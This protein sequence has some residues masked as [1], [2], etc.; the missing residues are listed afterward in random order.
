MPRSASATTS[1]RA[2]R[3]ERDHEMPGDLPHDEDALVREYE[4]LV[5]QLAS[6]IAK[7]YRLLRALDDLKSFGREGLI[8][9]ARGYDPERG[10]QFSTWA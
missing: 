1:E 3:P 5:V 7:R 8:L 2:K 4:G 10:T 6:D 9:A